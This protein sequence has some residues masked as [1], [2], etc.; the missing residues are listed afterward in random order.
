MNVQ[1]ILQIMDHFWDQ[2]AG[3]SEY[4][5][6]Q[7]SMSTYVKVKS[8]NDG[9]IEGLGLWGSNPLPFTIDFGK[10]FYKLDL[11]CTCQ[12]FKQASKNGDTAPCC[13]LIRALIEV[14]AKLR[15]RT[16]EEVHRDRLNAVIPF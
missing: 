16:F 8:F 1:S 13:H 4:K 12:S 9:K 7:W 14:E 3:S 2:V 5:H 6:L 11:E 15:H 10:D